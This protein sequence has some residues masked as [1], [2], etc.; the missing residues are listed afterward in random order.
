L[1]KNREIKA[2]TFLERISYTYSQPDACF[3]LAA[4][5]QQA[6]IKIGKGK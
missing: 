2:F 6:E 4:G 1:I 5:I 3:K